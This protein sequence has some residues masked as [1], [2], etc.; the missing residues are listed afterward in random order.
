MKRIGWGPALA[1]CAALVISCGGGSDST[2]PDTGI[3]PTFA[4]AKLTT[5]QD[6]LELPLLQSGTGLYADVS[7]KLADDG[8]FRVLSWRSAGLTAA[9]ADGTLNT[10]LAL[11][12]LAGYA[13]P[14]QLTLRRIHLDNEVYESVQI[15]LNRGRWRYLQP[16]TPA[17]A[18]STQDLR[19]N[20]NLFANEDHVVAIT[21]A[22]GSTEQFPLRL[23]SRNYRF[24]MD[25]QDQGA[26][27]VAILDPAGKVVLTLRAG[28][29]CGVLEAQ[30]GLYQVRH[31]YG[32]TGASRTVFLHKKPA[33]VTLTSVQDAPRDESWGIL[34]SLLDRTTHQLVQ[35]P[36]FLAF[37]GWT[38]TDGSCV[39]DV[40]PVVQAN[41]TSPIEWAPWNPAFMG[42]PLLN[43]AVADSPRRALFD[44]RN[45]FQPVRDPASGAPLA[46]GAPI[47]CPKANF[48]LHGFGHT[49]VDF[50]P[51]PDTYL[52]HFPNGPYVL[53]GLEDQDPDA[54]TFGAYL[55]WLVAFG[56]YGA[57]D[58][59]NPIRFA[60]YSASNT[61]FG[62]KAAFSVGQ[63]T[64]FDG[65]EVALGRPKA[66]GS[67]LELW[68]MDAGQA[69]QLLVEYRA[70]LRYRPTG[71]AGNTTPAAGQVALFNSGDCS[72]P[73]L[74][75]D[76]YDLPGMIPGPLGSFNGSLLL[77]T[78]T[79]ITAYQNVFFG[80]ASRQLISSGCIA[81]GADWKPASMRM[82]PVTA[83]MVFST[84][85]C[86]GCNLA[87]LD[88]GGRDMS[89]AKFA[90]SNLNNVNLAR[91]NLSGADLRQAFLQ[92]AQLPNANLD[93]A[94]MCG[95]KLN[96]A[97]ST[98]GSTNVAAN[99]SGAFLRNANLSRSNAAGA[100]F[101]AS[102]FFSASQS[103]CTP[104]AC[105]AYA[106]P[107]CATAAGA[108]I[109]AAQ[110]GNAYLAGADLSNAHGSGASF[111]NAVLIGARLNNAV[112]S[113]LNGTP[114]NFTG[115]FIQGA[116]FTSADLT[117]ATFT[118]AYDA[119]APGCMQFE[120]GAQYISFPGF[121]VPDPPDSTTCVPKTPV[122]PPTCVKFE[123]SQRTILPSTVVLGT[124]A[125]P[126]A[127]ASPPNSASCSVNP[128]CGAADPF[129]PDRVNTC[130]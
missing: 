92:G 62:L 122:V 53:T 24:C 42:I 110:F 129:L 28:G 2:L 55:S 26:D 90:G 73:A 35:T 121:T 82:H 95:A 83:E 71:F 39:G 113:P 13:Q 88:F 8:T 38:W 45:F 46:L 11:T 103:A 21:S 101:N 78:L 67:G 119:Q 29:E 43:P 47:A 32:G 126:L 77:G 40:L 118:N 9:A 5:A 98:A 74:V 6:V 12:D 127:Q 93:A 59:D 58:F 22:P 81:S 80:G 60:N 102:S 20:S 41:A 85:G 99:L 79:S 7:I 114:A 10:Q 107:T 18:L 61:S 51:T 19:A 14:V 52:A 37:R 34:A 27:S 31:T 75:V 15:E 4:V 96:A 36:V 109:D 84:K 66:D 97:P 111:S 44:Q 106:R 68:P 104:A 16:P 108:T 70:A 69:D 116:D 123:F 125:V 89:N 100:N 117:G 48:S 56:A 63:K 124:P 72:G 23:D 120:L 54:G 33:P 50:I 1:V 128:L 112:L 87:G 115:S 49:D 94:N 17:K 91:A 65:T 30:Q 86:E 105:D 3:A 76:Q 57:P 64:P 130:W 25:A